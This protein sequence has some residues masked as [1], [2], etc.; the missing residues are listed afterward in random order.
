MPDA[1]PPAD[2]DEVD[3][4]DEVDQVDQVDEVDEVDDRPRLVRFSLGGR[5]LLVD[6]GSVQ[7]VLVARPVTRLPGA[8]DAVCGVTSVRGR[9]VAVVDASGVLGT[10]PPP[11]RRWFVVVTTP[12][13]PV[14]LV[15]DRVDGVVAAD[16]DPV[17]LVDAA[18]VGSTADPGPPAVAAPLVVATATIAGT[19][20]D[21]VDAVAAIAAAIDAGR[22]TGATP[23]SDAHPGS[24]HRG[25][26]PAT[27]AA[28]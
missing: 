20:I 21:V 6:V 25:A 3:E 26:E 23:S 24:H 15:V 13:G 11:A 18:D 28:P 22:A 1:H 10:D 8:V 5:D 17:D 12:S 4:V 7:E 2:L 16:L 9:I 14:A 27:A 19:V